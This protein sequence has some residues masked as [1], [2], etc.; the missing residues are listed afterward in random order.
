MTITLGSIELNNNLQIK[1]LYDQPRIAGSA[2]ATIGGICIQ[3]LAMAGGRLLQLVSEQSNQ[4]LLGYFT[5]GQ[6][7]SIAALRDAG[8]PI[9]LT[10]DTTSWSVWIPPDGVTTQKLFDHQLPDA[11]A[12]YSGTITL[13]TVS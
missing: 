1:G 13:I 8:L 2:R 9:T 4:G 11:D 5:G 10:K 7:A 12:W 6:L 3:Q